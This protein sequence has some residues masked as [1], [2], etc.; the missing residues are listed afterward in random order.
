[1]TARRGRFSADEGAAAFALFPEKKI[2]KL[3]CEMDDALVL[4]SEQLLWQN[5][6]PAALLAFVKLQATSR[7]VWRRYRYDIALWRRIGQSLPQWS[8]PEHM[9]PRRR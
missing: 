6:D 5:A 1:M 9:G 4:V 2:K 8:L 3:C 7:S